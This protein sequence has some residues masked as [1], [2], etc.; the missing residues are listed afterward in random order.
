MITVQ[1][2]A[3]TG[4]NILNVQPENNDSPDFSPE[5]Y[6]FDKESSLLNVYYMVN[7]HVYQI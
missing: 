3:Q 2:E 1:M 6:E 5:K 7:I 4:S